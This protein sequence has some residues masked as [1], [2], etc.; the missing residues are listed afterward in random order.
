MMNT[1]IDLSL[2][3]IEETHCN[4]TLGQ[5]D[6]QRI[7]KR[8]NPQ[9][10]W[11]SH[12]HILHSGLGNSHRRWGRKT[13]IVRASSDGMPRKQSPLNQ[14]NQSP[15]ELIE[16]EEA[17]TGHVQVCTRF[18]THILWLP[19]YVF[20]GFQSMQMSGSLALLT[21]F[22]LFYFYLFV[23]SNSDVSIFPISN[24]TISYFIIIA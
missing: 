12:F 13:A 22:G 2:C 20:N 3:C 15:H 14:H 18:S 10:S 1:K 24:L 23:L 16:T 5:R 6:G 17:C 4:I 9:K 19:V 21:F 11:C 7:F 8:M